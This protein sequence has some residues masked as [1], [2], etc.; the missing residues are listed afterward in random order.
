MGDGA[1]VVIADATGSGNVA[2]VLDDGTNK[3]LAVE[4][5]PATGH[6]LAL[7]ATQASIK[8]TDGIKKITDELPAGTQE[9]GA[10]K[11]GTKAAGSGAWPT[12]L[13]DADGNAVTITDDAGVRRVEILGKVVVTGATPPPLTTPAIIFAST[14]LTVGSD[15]TDF[16][17]PDGESF[18]LQEI[19]AGNEDPSKGASVEVIYDNG[20]EHLVARVYIAGVTVPTGFPDEHTSRD[21][22]EMAGNAGQTFKIIVRRIKFTGSDIAIDAEVRGYTQ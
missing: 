17:I 5:R 7:E 8:D 2:E 16:I 4:S 1:G 15:D 3:R 11:Q 13:Y 21:G 20:T 6:G 22:T 14:P 10:V 12:T 9:I 18:F 19:L